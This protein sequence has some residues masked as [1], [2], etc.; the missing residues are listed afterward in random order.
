MAGRDGFHRSS[1]DVNRSFAGSRTLGG[2]GSRGAMSEIL[3]GPTTQVAAPPPRRQSDVGSLLGGQAAESEQR[4]LR[5]RGSAA[6]SKSAMDDVMH[7]VAVLD[8]LRGPKPVQKYNS[9][10]SVLSALRPE[11]SGADATGEDPFAHMRVRPKPAGPASR[12]TENREP[13]NPFVEALAGVHHE[14]CQLAD[15][16]P[17]LPTGQLVDFRPL[18]ELL[19]KRN[20]PVDADSAGTLIATIDVNRTISY[21]E[22]VQLLAS[23]LQEEAPAAPPA[24]PAPAPAQQAAKPTQLAFAQPAGPRVHPTQSFG[25]YDPSQWKASAQPSFVPLVQPPNTAAI[26]RGMLGHGSTQKAATNAEL[27]NVLNAG[28]GQHNRRSNPEYVPTYGKSAQMR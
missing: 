18:L 8:P 28:L 3:G 5:M 10:S 25:Q 15:S 14:F 17:R 4:S 12:A 24:A 21:D 9:G 6:A 2:D 1:A 16:L 26:T 7:G 22:F 13:V 20:L 23:G 11:I 19:S 27:V